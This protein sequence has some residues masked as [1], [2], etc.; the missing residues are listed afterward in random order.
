MARIRFRQGVV[1]IGAVFVF[2]SVRQAPDARAARGAAAAQTAAR[3]SGPVTAEERPQPDARGLA[4]VQ[5][6]AG[7]FEMGCVPDDTV[8]G[9]DEK[10]R[11]GVTITRAFQLLKAE[12]SVG[13][14]R[15]SNAPVPSQPS[16][17]SDVRHP[18]VG[19]TWDEARAF[20][21]WAGGRLPSE[22]EWEY[23]AR[24]GQ[25]GGMYPWGSSQAPLI[26]GRPAANVADEA[27]RRSHPTWTIFGGYDDG[28]AQTAP[29][30]SFAANGYG[31]VDIAG[32]VW[33]W[34][35]DWYD[36]V[37]Y[38]RSPKLD[39]PGPSS[40][41]QRALRGGSWADHPKLLRAS[42]RLRSA[43]ENRSDFFGFRCARDAPP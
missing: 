17:S 39:P 4:W 41:S 5:I 3:Q 33:E 30:G 14:F 35:S 21:G 19:V 11:H 2:T 24:G 25:A 7:T 16:W 23:A 13:Q 12:V 26:A 20:C 38:S 36:R 9:I 1:A 31:L 32:N 40:G 43:P 34:T 8:C 37:Y 28:F 22:A 6:P 15:G 10:P 18:V 27:A 42:I 29:A